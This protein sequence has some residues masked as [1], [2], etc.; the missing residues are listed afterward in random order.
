VVQNGTDE[1]RGYGVKKRN[2]SEHP[3]LTL[4]VGGRKE[5]CLLDTGS[6][7]TIFNP[8]EGYTDETDENFGT[9]KVLGECAVR[10]Q[11]FAGEMLARRRVGVRVGWGMRGTTARVLF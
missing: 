6:G 11:S 4:E 9:L 3:F 10:I 8:S 1:T 7:I 2:T 5:L